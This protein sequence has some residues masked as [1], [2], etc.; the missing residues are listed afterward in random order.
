[1]KKEKLE[2]LGEISLGDF[3][4][5]IKNKSGKEKEEINVFTI[6]DLNFELGDKEEKELERKIQIVDKGRFNSESLSKEN[7]VVVGLTI[8]KAC[9]ISKNNVGKIITSNF[10]I[11]KFDEEKVDSNYFIWYFNEHP[12]IKKYLRLISQGSA[13][14]SAISIGMLRDIEIELPEIEIQRIIGKIYKLR[15]EKIKLNKQKEELEAKLQ[16]QIILNQMEE[17]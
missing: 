11:I 5:R 4:A 9:S 16:N 6:N 3:L 13:L 17:K 2:N 1:M 14:V 15:I 10:A 7:N 8:N 12:S